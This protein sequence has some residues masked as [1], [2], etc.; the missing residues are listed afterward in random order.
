VVF[1]K[2]ILKNSLIPIITHVVIQVPF[3]ITGSVLL[4]NFFQIPG[5]GNVVAVSIH[6]SDFPVLKAM[7]LLGALLFVTFHLLT[8]LLYAWVDPR[9]KLES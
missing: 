1:F 4:E 3:L 8:D 5:L 6:N 2:H 9:I 7:V